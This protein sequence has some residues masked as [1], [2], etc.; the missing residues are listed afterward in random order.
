M[1]TSLKYFLNRLANAVQVSASAPPV[2]ATDML[3]VV[4]SSK[5][6]IRSSSFCAQGIAVPSVIQDRAK[7]FLTL[8]FGYS[9]G[10]TV[11]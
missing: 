11:K 5:S 9:S 6:R 1:T 4:S 7:S 2:G 3:A 8:S 10:F